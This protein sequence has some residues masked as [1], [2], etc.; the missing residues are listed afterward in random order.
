[1]I[2]KSVFENE[3]IAGMQQELRKQASGET[4]DLVKAGEC[5]HAALEILEDAGL[6]RHADKVLGI[7]HKI[8]ADSTKRI[9][10]VPTLQELMRHGLTTEDIQSFGRGDTGA[11]MKMN[12][13][14]RKM[15]LGE[16]EIAQ[17]IGKHNVVPE[18]ELKTYQKF[19]GWMQD[20]FK[21]DEGPVQPGQTVELQSLPQLPENESNKPVGEEITFKSL[22]SKPGRPDRISDVHTKKLTPAKMV[23][24]LKHHG[25][26]FNM[27]DLGWAD[28]DPELADALDAH[29]ADEMNIEDIFDADI[30]D[31]TLEV[32]DLV[33][34]EDFEDEVSSPK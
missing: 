33:P 24:N 29:S 13:V 20:P 5:L 12:L 9:H 1:M 8:A 25:T 28:F 27:P 31:D 19:M 3:L 14:L 16:H 22:A 2:K 32:S 26:E 34:L 4:P 11:K 30:A 18:H 7:L 21:V 10:K 17:F 15:D 6:S 23:E